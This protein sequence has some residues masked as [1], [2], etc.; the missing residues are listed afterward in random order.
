M[1]QSDVVEGFFFGEKKKKCGL[2]NLKN[3]S[4]KIVYSKVKLTLQVWTPNKAQNHAYQSTV[5]SDQAHKCVPS[6]HEKG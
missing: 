2:G 6:A 3:L 1:D 4:K 5:K